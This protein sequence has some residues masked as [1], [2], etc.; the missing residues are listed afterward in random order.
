MSGQ[1][2]FEK[3]YHYPHMR[4]EDKAIWERFIDA[5]P[6]YYDSVDYDVP[7]GSPPDFSTIVNL[8]TGGDDALLYKRKID[9]VGYRVGGK[10]I[11]ELKPKADA[12]AFG[13]AI[14]YKTLYCRDVDPRT[15]CTP[16]VITDQIGRDMEELAKEMGVKLLAA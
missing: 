2:P 11:I 12:R 10:D 8:D 15:E 16:T 14:G 4:D 1:Y 7:V 9:V 13:Q 6:G 3:R 5:Y